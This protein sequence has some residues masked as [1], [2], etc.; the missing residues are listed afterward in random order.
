VLAQSWS[1]SD[2]FSY[3]SSGK[4]P[5][6]YVLAV[7]ASTGT[8][9][10]SVVGVTPVAYT[11][12]AE[13]SGVIYSAQAYTMTCEEAALAM[14][15]SHEGISVSQQQVLNAEG[16]QD[17]SNGKGVGPKSVG[18]GDPMLHFVGDPNGNEGLTWEPGAYYGAIAIAAKNLGG[19]VIADGEGI[20]PAQVYTYVAEN[21][22]VEVWVTFDFHIDYGTSWLSNGIHTWPW[23]GPDGHVVTIVGVSNNA[24]EIDNPWD[25]GTH[26]S[27]YYGADQWVP[28][29]VFQSVYAVYND[30]AVV[31]N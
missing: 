10:Q 8:A 19:N 5:G 22:P 27:E 18:T 12:S 13:V 11:G 3:G 4:P 9:Y 6:N 30:M 21:H 24:V 25:A 20:T 23:A 15:L 1:T 17:D 31:L 28:M 2:T 14:A 26:G 16:I 7:W 29:S